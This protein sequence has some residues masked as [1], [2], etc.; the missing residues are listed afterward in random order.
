MVSRHENTYL[1]KDSAISSIRLREPCPACA[2]RE[3]IQSLCTY[4]RLLR[5]ERD[6]FFNMVVHV[7][8]MEIPLW[9]KDGAP[10]MGEGY[11]LT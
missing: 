9:C 6:Q 8:K 7:R 3:A 10:G 4:S 11:L 2:G 1:R 5:S